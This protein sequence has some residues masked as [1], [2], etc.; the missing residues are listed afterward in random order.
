M[1]DN[2]L[3]APWERFYDLS[4]LS[5]AGD[6]VV[7]A[8][9]AEAR[10]GVALWAE[11]E[12]IERFEARITLSRPSHTHFGYVAEL[13][14]DFTQSCVVTLE[15]VPGH[16]EQTIRRDLYLPPRAR[17]LSRVEIPETLVISTD[18]EEG[19]EK[20]TSSRFDLAAPLLE[21]FSLAL[22]PYP[23]ADGIAFEAPRDS[24]D[25]KESPFAVLARL[26]AKR[27]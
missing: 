20:I 15:P 21:E 23:R 3:I 25:V 16:I 14:S 7:I 8:L 18:S 26:K 24:S 5:D 11:I 17:R 13:I 1:A 22:D 27:P 4:A 6:E 2:E 12:G 9:D 19:P 10:K